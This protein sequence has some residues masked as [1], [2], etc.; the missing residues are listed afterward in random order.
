MPDTTVPTIRCLG[1]DPIQLAHP[2][3]EVAVRGLNHQV[4]LVTH[5][6]IGKASPIECCDNLSEDLQELRSVRIIFVDGFPAVASGGDMLERACEFD[7]YGPRH[8]LDH[9]R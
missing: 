1:I 7:A 2:F 3:R 5:Q 6:T 8:A 9:S 4:V